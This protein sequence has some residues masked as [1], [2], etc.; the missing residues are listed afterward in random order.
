[1]CIHFEKVRMYMYMIMYTRMHARTRVHGTCTIYSTM[2]AYAC[3]SCTMYHAPILSSILSRNFLS[4]SMDISIYFFLPACYMALYSIL[5]LF[6][7]LLLFSLATSLPYYLPSIL[8]YFYTTDI[9][10]SILQSINSSIPFLPQPLQAILPIPLQHHR[11]IEIQRRKEIQRK[12]IHIYKCL[13]NQN[14]YIRILYI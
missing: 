3:D 1:M 9:Y 11:D 5:Q 4:L 14:L 2:I 13:C 10:I 7:S 12:R 6:Y 8:L